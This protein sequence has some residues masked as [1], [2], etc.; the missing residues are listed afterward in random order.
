MILTYLRQTFISELQPPIEQAPD[1]TPNV[2][3]LGDINVDFINLTNNR[4]RDCLAIF[5]L[6]NVIKEHTRISVN[7]STLIDPIIVSDA[8]QVF[9]S[10]TITVDNSISDHKATYVSIKTKTS[11]DESYVREVLNY[12]NANFDELNEKIRNFNWNDVIIDTFSADEA[13]N[14]FTEV[15]VN[16]CKSCIPRK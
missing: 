2:I 12:K 7:L 15:Y 13:C 4:F 5:N 9:D 3:L 8:C 16:L 14:N 10:S 1:Y 6:S 11:L